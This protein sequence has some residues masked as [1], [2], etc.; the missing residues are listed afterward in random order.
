MKILLLAALSMSALLAQEAK[1]KN[2]ILSVKLLAAL[3]INHDG[4]ISA[5]EID[6]AAVSLK[7]L[8]VDHDGKITAYECGLKGGL[9]TLGP[10]PEELVAALMAFDRNR[11][12]RL[13]RAEV[14]ERMQGLFDRAD[15]AK[16]G[17]LTPDQIRKVAEEDNE[18]RADP[19]PYPGYA[20]RA[21]V[22]YMRR[23][24]VN[25][26]LDADHDGEVSASEIENAPKAL[27]TLDR[28]G[29][30]KLTEDEVSSDPLIA[31]IAQ[32]MLAADT[33]GD[34]SLSKEE[35]SAESARELFA[36]IKAAEVDRRGYVTEAALIAEIS[37]RAD[38][39]HDGVVTA[40]ELQQA[41]RSGALGVPPVKR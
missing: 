5:N 30:G 15:T 8:D 3:D 32:F 39:N 33:D 18:K 29:D 6:H 12:G 4:V 24:P 36:A 38:A 28:N 31:L 25:Y 11:D 35:A 26:A 16:K 7:V 19:E 13:E 37:K 1:S 23:F 17:V 22:A 2:I 40:E 27:R 9:D 34:G 10:S 21:R 41:L 20:K 14:P